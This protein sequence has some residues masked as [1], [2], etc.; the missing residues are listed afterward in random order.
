M[1]GI[2]YAAKPYK[3]LMVEIV[4]DKLPP[5]SFEAPDDLIYKYSKLVFVNKLPL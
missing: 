2:F 1:R 3:T 5:K 4:H